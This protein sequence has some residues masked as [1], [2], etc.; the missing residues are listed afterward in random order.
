MLGLLVEERDL[1]NIS[2][3]KP[4]EYTEPGFWG[5]CVKGRG[6]IVRNSLVVWTYNTRPENSSADYVLQESL[7]DTLFISE[8]DNSLADTLYGGYL[9]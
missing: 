6:Y 5:G 4:A 7:G 3:E 8:V 1:V 9:L 2:W